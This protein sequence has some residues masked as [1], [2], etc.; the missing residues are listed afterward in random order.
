MMIIVCELGLE[1][2]YLV[3]EIKKYLLVKVE[4]L[5]YLCYE[6]GSVQFFLMLLFFVV[7]VCVCVVKLDELVLFFGDL[8]LEKVCVICCSVKECVF[9]INVL[10]VLCQVSLIGNICDILFVVLVGGLLLD[11]EV[12]Q[13]VIDVLVYYCLVVG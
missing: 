8:V 12:L 5:F 10:C 6:D 9:V 13:L 1:D 2:C 4:S 3:E 11:F 7:F